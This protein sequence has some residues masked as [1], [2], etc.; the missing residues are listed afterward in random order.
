MR[1]AEIRISRNQAAVIREGGGRRARLRLW[2]RRGKQRTEDRGPV[3]AYGYAEAS[4]GQKT[5]DPSSPMA[6]PRQA[7]DGQQ[8]TERKQRIIDKEP[9]DIVHFPVKIGKISGVFSTKN[10]GSCA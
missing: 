8:R 4:R 3:F 6:T 7:E 5:E 10:D 9:K 1:D 2:L